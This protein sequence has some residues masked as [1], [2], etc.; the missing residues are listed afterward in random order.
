MLWFEFYALQTPPPTITPIDT[1]VPLSFIHPQILL[2]T[3]TQHVDI[4]FFMSVSNRPHHCT[5]IISTTYTPSFITITYK[6]YNVNIIQI[7]IKNNQHNSSPITHTS[8][9]YHQFPLFCN[10]NSSVIIIIVHKKNVGNTN[11]YNN[12]LSLYS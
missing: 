11:N 3:L 9:T 2:H 1:Y 10:D 6:S 4:M 5:F 8:Q 7:T 12:V